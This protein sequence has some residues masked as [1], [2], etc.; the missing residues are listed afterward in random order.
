MKTLTQEQEWA[1]AIEVADEAKATRRNT[2]RRLSARH[3]GDRRQIS[4]HG[5]GQESIQFF[6]PEGLVAD[7]TI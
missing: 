5:C 7:Y 4:Q 3:K 2:I 1:L 6:G